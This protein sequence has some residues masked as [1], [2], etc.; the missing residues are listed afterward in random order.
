MSEQQMV[1]IVDDDESVRKSLAWILES[2]NL[3]FTE[4]SSGYEF[5]DEAKANVPSCLI[6]DLQMPELS[7]IDV[8]KMMKV[9]PRLTMP[10]VVLTG[11]GSVVTAVQS[12]RLGVHDFLEKPVDHET[13]LAKV[14]EAL[15]LDKTRRAHEAEVSGIKSR[16]ALLTGREREVL[17]FICGGKSNKQ[18]AAAL[19]ISIKTVTIHRWHMM[20]K[21]QANTATELML[22]AAPLRLGGAA[23]GK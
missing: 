22:L 23:R 20:K 9:S 1:H 21:M 8:L 11:T 2:A 19:G 14:R 15:T 13:L 7:G 12:M 5:L 17:Q 6:L 18:I 10:V 4:Y 16:V 3:P